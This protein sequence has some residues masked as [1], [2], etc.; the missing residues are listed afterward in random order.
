MKISHQP[1]ALIILDGWGHRDNPQY[2]AIA[3]AGIILARQVEAKVII[4]GTSSGQ[5]ARNLAAY[6]PPIPVIVATDNQRVYQRMA[7]LWGSKAFLTKHLSLAND[8]VITELRQAG[9][10]DYGDPVVVAYGHHKGVVGG[11]DTVQ[12]K[13]VE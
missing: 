13:V 9:N 3:A 8:S 6:R 11:T 10:V 7:L 5:T 1:I 2:N 4:A 12:V